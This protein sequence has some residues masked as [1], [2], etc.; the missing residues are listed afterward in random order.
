LSRL[1]RLDFRGAIHIVHVRGRDGFN[2]FFD[3]AV[4]A[5]TGTE[6][7]RG[8]P[9]LLRFLQLLDE[10]C[11][12]C[13]AQLFG[14]CI[15]P[16]ECAFVL[17]NLGLALEACMQRVGGRYSRYLH[18][19]S[20]LPKSVCPFETRYESKVLAPEYLP[21]ALRRVHAR[22]VQAGLVRRAIDYPFSSAA[23]YLGETAFVK[24]ESD[25]VWGTLQRKGLPGLRGYKEFMER[26][27]TP[28]V[29]ELFE[30]GARADERV[31]GDRA[32]VVMARDAAG[33]PRAPVSREQLI[34]GVAA[35]L[36][37]RK[38]ELFDTNHQAVLGRALV[39]CYALLFGVATLREVGR[40]FAVSGTALGKAIRY[41]RRVA[42]ELF[43]KQTLPGI[44]IDDERMGG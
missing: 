29:S 30:R 31:V 2:I 8:A 43:A 36:G 26:T 10:C 11:S 13:G 41:Y 34:A 38:E 6:R 35:L 28:H 4:L 37:V 19:E 32:F 1:S 5:L 9:H 7:R 17:R 44:E 25:V 14:Y 3:R 42:P 27:E 33:H 24:L 23:T 22:P 39:A 15:E 18:D 20:V 40:W 21:Y 16:N 12:E